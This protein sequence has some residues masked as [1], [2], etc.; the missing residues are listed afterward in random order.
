MELKIIEDFHFWDHKNLWLEWVNVVFKETHYDK[1]VNI[2]YVKKKKDD[3]L[4]IQ[5]DHDKD[6]D[7]NGT[8]WAIWYLC[9]E[10][11]DCCNKKICKHN[12]E[13]RKAQIFHL[14]GEFFIICLNKSTKTRFENIFK[15]I[16]YIR[17]NHGL[18]F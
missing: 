1:D 14:D 17:L 9:D 2:I 6:F 18:Y 11:G 12:N 5:P 10:T 15:L 3:E 8:Y 13:Y 16:F 7:P 4:H